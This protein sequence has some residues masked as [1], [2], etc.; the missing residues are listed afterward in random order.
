MRNPLEDLAMNEI[1][2]F[3]WL[4]EDHTLALNSESKRIFDDFKSR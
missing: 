3:N 2:K 4:Y 1:G